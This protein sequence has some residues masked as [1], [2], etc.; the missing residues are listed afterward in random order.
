M[1]EK[2]H[3]T[4]TTSGQMYL[5]KDFSVELNYKL[6]VTKGS[7]FV[8][9]DRLKTVSKLSSTSLGFLSSYMI[10]LGLLSAFKLDSLLIIPN[11]YLAFITTG[12][13]II[14]LVFSQSESS[15]EYGLKAEKF[16]NCALE[17]SDLYNKLRYLKTERSTDL[18]INK[19]SQELSIEYGIILK[20]YENHKPIDFEYFKTSKPDYFKLSMWE[21]I[22][23]KSIFYLKTKFLYHFLIGSPPVLIYFIL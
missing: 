8:A 19:L 18:D 9:S 20:R 1:N 14:I 12:L 16:H 10:L 22:K 3:E 15:S 17:I 6:W 2:H 13:S 23:I 4:K 7:R 11:Q 21:T 5:D